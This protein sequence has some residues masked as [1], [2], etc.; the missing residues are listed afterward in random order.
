MP[1]VIYLYCGTDKPDNIET[2]FNPF[3]LE[4]LE[5]EK[6]GIVFQQKWYSVQV[7]GITCDTEARKW[8]KGSKGHGGEGGCDRCIQKGSSFGRGRRIFPEF[9]SRLRTN[10]SFRQRI[11]A[12]H[13][14]KTSPLEK[15]NIDMFRSF[16]LDYMQLV[17]YY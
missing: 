10:E 2:F 8:V 3:L 13:H 4:M 6:T 15:L 5:L 11:N 1:F 14:N 9:N 17:R 12:N 16:P 7:V